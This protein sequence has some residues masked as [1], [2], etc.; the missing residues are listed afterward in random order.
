MNR[1][2]KLYRQVTEEEMGISSTEIWENTVTGMNFILQNS[3]NVM[4]FA[5]FWFLIGPRN[6]KIDD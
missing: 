6:N 5:P 4:G 1:S 2:E 3:G